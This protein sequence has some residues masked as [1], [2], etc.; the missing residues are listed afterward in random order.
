M[1]RLL[2][3]AVLTALIHAVN[4]MAYG[5]RLVGVRT[6]R[7]ATAVSLFNIV[8]LVASAAN[9]IQA[10]LLSSLV[11]QVINTALSAASPGGDLFSNPVYRQ[12]L[13]SLAGDLRSVILAASLGT[14][15]G[16]ILIPPFVRILSRAVLFFDEVGSVPR[17]LAAA[18]LSP[19]RTLRF[20][21]QVQLPRPGRL[22]RGT[23]RERRRLPATF[24]LLNVVVTGIYT[25]GVLSALYAGALFPE[26]RGTAILLSGIVNGIATVLIA[27]V[28][29]PTA[30]RITDQAA[31][32]A[33]PEKDVQIM[34]AY[35][36]GTRFLGT[37]FAQALLLPAAELIKAAAVFIAP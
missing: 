29:D 28:V 10:P 11:E 34:V 31:R 36:T 26:F 25:I 37:I 3:V 32:G 22:L 18:V 7:L 27:T 2:L 17:M 6:Q 33:R 8:F 30:A 1:E 23:A 21:R 16:G 20:L 9:M 12:G 19:R 13:Q 4:T 5:V 15:A 14:L 24:L 35:L